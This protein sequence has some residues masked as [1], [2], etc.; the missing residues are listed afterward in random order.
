MS[1]TAV[2]ASITLRACTLQFNSVHIYPVTS[3]KFI[4]NVSENAACACPVLS[5]DAQN[6]L[7]LPNPG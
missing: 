7:L 5:H 4:K 3:V 1:G 6:R 2:S